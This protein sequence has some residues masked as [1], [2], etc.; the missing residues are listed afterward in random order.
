MSDPHAVAQTAARV[1]GHM[2]NLSLSL[3]LLPV[4]RGSVW[5]AAFGVPFDRALVYHRA[6]GRLAWLFT[7]LHM[8]V[9]MAKWATQGTLWHNVLLMKSS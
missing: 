1:L 4:A 2:S 8:P 3:V 5:E 6:M 7:T 9:W